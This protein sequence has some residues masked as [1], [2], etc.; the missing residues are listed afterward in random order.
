MGP[1]GSDHVLGLSLSHLEA[2]RGRQ[3]QSTQSTTFQS[4]VVNYL[5]NAMVGNNCTLPYGIS[6]GDTMALYL[7]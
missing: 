7:K 6:I 4:C 2:V 1:A 3:T 5:P